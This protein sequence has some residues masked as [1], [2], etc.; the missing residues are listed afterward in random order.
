[1]GERLLLSGGATAM[2]A[3]AR[4]ERRPRLVTVYNFELADWH[5]YHVRQRTRLGVRA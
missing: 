3:S 4:T 2:V 5:T 1:M